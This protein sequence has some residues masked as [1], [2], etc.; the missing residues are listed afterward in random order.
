LFATVHAADIN[1]AL[2]KSATQSSNYNTTLYH[3]SQA[4]NGDTQGV[5]YKKFTRMR[6][7]HNS[8]FSKK[9]TSLKIKH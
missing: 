1:L 9:N 7:V 3:A 4:V 8:S 2:G 5:W 6:Y